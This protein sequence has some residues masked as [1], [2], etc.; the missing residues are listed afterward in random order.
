M[1]IKQ[2]MTVSFTGLVVACLYALPVMADEVD[3]P[4]AKQTLE[5]NESIPM[6]WRVHQENMSPEERA[7][8]RAERKALREKL[9]N[10]TPEEKRAYLEQYREEKLANMTPEERKAFE[11]H[12]AINLRG[13]NEVRFGESINRN[14]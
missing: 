13:Q 6:D 9:K 2:F 1:K 3:N 11:E 12:R 8:H 4:P 5:Q 14:V 10:M 7:K